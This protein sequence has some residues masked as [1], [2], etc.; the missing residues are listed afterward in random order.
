MTVKLM[1]WDTVV[2]ETETE[3]DLLSVPVV[4]TDAEG[5]REYTSLAEAF[6]RD[7]ALVVCQG[8]EVLLYGD[9]A[10]GF[11]GDWPFDLMPVRADQASWA[12]TSWDWVNGEGDW[13]VDVGDA[14]EVDVHGFYVCS[15]ELYNMDFD[16]ER[17]D[18][19]QV[20]K[21]LSIRQG[22]SSMTTGEIGCTL[23]VDAWGGA[24]VE[25]WGGRETFVG[26]TEIVD[27]VASIS[28]PL[29][30]DLGESAEISS[31]LL[32]EAQMRAVVRDLLEARWLDLNDGVDISGPG[33]ESSVGRLRAK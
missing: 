8:L 1:L 32:I 13:V 30:M 28:G 15:I 5:S 22:S 27:P 2:V 12:G 6:T 23:R 25:E 24:W 33:Y 21:V 3:A 14:A 17:I 11:S 7:R 19:S 26:R 10:E 31:E 29:E 16:A 20:G 18:S 4:V 9:F